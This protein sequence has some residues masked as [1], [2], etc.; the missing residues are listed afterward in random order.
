MAQHTAEEI[1][2]IMRARGFSVTTTIDGHTATQTFLSEADR[3][4]FMARAT[5]C[6]AVVEKAKGA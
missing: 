1:R 3:D 4:E 5:R 2:A 6:G